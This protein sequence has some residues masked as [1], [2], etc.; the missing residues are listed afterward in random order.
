[1]APTQHRAAIEATADPAAR[2]AALLAGTTSK[3]GETMHGILAEAIMLATEVVHPENADA[4]VGLVASVLN[5]TV[6]EVLACG[7]KA[8][9][10]VAC[11]SGPAPASC[12]GSP[13]R[14]LEP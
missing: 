14:G 3:A 1:M 8:L 9:E 11:L 7:K 5:A 2:E 12:P 13:A 6:A 4:W 10:G